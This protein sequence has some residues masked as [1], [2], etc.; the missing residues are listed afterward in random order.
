[1]AIDWLTQMTT[2]LVEVDKNKP[3]NRLNDGK[4][5]PVGRLLA[6]NPNYLPVVTMTVAF[7]I[8]MADTLG[9]RYNGKGGATC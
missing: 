7:G 2:T 8:I 4:V 5:D 1:M 9:F 3:N 6:G